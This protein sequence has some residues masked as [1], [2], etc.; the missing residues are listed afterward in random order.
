MN[1]EP[2]PLAGAGQG[3]QAAIERLGRSGA[4]PNARTVADDLR[5][6]GNARVVIKVANQSAIT[7]VTGPAPGGQDDV[8]RIAWQPFHQPKQPVQT[9]RRGS[10]RRSGWCV[11]C[12]RRPRCCD[13]GHSSNI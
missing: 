5:S 8:A 6:L 12:A 13:N 9:L 2:G 10:G 11:A 1:Y 4:S 7:A 3:R